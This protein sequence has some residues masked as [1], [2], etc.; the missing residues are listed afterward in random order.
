MTAMNVAAYAFTLFAARRLGPDGYSVVAALMG[1]V[2]VVN[3]LALG[4][5]ATTARQVAS[6]ATT[7]RSRPR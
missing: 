3:V 6:T 5:Q 7:R 2:L 4:V 1:V